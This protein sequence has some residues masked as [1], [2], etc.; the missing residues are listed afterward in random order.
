[1][2]RIFKDRPFTWWYRLLTQYLLRPSIKLLSTIRR[3][4]HPAPGT[5]LADNSVGQSSTVGRK[6]WRTAHAESVGRLVGTGGV[7]I[8][9]HIRGGDACA[10]RRRPT[11]CVTLAHAITTL[12]LYGITEGAII[13]AIRTI[14]QMSNSMPVD[15]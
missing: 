11:V 3:I 14:I 5:I 13:L 9:M 2:P 10:D 7:T 1:M 12:N 4:A 8:G 6:T 15:M